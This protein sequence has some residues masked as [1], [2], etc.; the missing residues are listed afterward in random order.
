MN[1]S[2]VPELPNFVFE[3]FNEKDKVEKL[4]HTSDIKKFLEYLSSKK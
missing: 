3:V 4:E 1:D 2:K